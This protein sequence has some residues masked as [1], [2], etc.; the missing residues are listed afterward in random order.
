VGAAIEVQSLSKRYGRTVAVE[1]LSF[2]VQPGRV[3]GFVGPNGAGKSTTMR[4]ILGLDRPTE[5]RAL[6]GGAPYATA[7]SPLRL[8]GGLLDAQALH[9]G[10]TAYHHLLWLAQSNGLPVGR[11]DVALGTVG[12]DAV[13][14][15]RAG[16]F[17]LGMKQRLGL[18]AALLGDPAIL[19]LDEPVNGLDPEGIRWIRRFLASMA[20]EGRAVFVSSHLL[21]E[22]EGMADQL[23]IIGRGRLIADVSVQ[24]LLRRSSPNRFSVRASDPARAASVLEGA[25]ATVTRTEEGMMTVEGLPAERL[26]DVAAQNG[27][28]LLELTPLRASLEDV[29]LDLTRPA[30]DYRSDPPRRP[31]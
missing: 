21:G 16:T 18:A 17:S 4:L 7:R 14:G 11:V 23:V 29:V 9:P 3:T 27:V 12:L 20:A 13:G 8:V 2:S 30:V 15:R 10:R 5:G 26:A 24:D 6:V 25:G 28:V 31:E 22:L 19:M 1:G